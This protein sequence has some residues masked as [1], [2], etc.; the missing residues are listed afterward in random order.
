MRSRVGFAMVELIVAVLIVGVLAAVAM[1]L[2]SG[3]I[4][5]SKWSEGKAAMGTIAS[6]LNRARR[7][8][9]DRL[10]EKSRDAGEGS[11]ACGHLKE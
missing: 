11:P 2:M 9:R 6:A 3:R 10:E 4:D 7:L 1:P 8:L 5:A